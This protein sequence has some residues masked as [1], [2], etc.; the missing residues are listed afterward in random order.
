MEGGRKFGNS[1]GD[2]SKDES[3]VAQASGVDGVVEISLP[4]HDTSLPS[5]DT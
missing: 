4:S 5:T 3:L 1:G 2:D